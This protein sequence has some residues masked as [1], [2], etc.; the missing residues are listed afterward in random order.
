VD[1]ALTFETGV[2]SVFFVG[3]EPGPGPGLLSSPLAM[4]GAFV[5]VTE[6]DGAFPLPSEA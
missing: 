2:G 4:N 6:G 5:L 1:V 3:P